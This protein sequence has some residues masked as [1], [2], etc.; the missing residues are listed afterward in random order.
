MRR[1]EDRFKLAG[2]AALVSG[3]CGG[4]GSTV[5]RALAGLGASVAVGDKDAGG[6]EALA[7]ELSG[8]GVKTAAVVF[9]AASVQETARAVEET[10]QR[11]NG[12]DILVNCVGTHR[13]QKA[14]EVTEEAFDLVYQ[15][16]L[17]SA[18]FQAQAAARQMM[19][20]GR[21]GKQV[22][23]G[24]VR[25]LLGLRGRG[26][27]AYCATKGGLG[28]LCK[29]LAA[30][31]A[32]HKINVNMVAP[33][34][35]RTPLVADM[36]ADESFYG[37]LVSRIPLGRIAEPE[38]VALAVAF[39]CSPASDFITGQILYVDGGVTATQ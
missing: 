38:D 1:I 35:V 31:W 7:E 6:A 34:F 29:Q 23:I 4:I 27:A 18:M 3:G 30:E 11:L 17:K 20:Q 13:E 10:A 9:D 8:L 16:N 39:L 33:T 12:L 28:T 21:G 32:P 2:K 22:H 37:A 5:C 14:E 19:R 26:Y 24:S 15:L 25:T 36:L